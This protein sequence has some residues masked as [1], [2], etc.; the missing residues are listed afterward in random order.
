M[1]K[2][3]NSKS[4]ATI[5]TAP[6]LAAFESAEVEN[7]IRAGLPNGNKLSTDQ[8][9]AAALAARS[10]DLNPFLRE[11][12]ITDAG[13]MK[14][15]A[16]DAAWANEWMRAMG[17]REPE[18]SYVTPGQLRREDLIEWV[19]KLNRSIDDSADLATAFRA[20]CEALNY[21]P[22]T[23]V[24]VLAR[25]HRF[26]TRDA[27]VRNVQAALLLGTKE[28]VRALYGL[29]PAPDHEAWGIV[30]ASEYK[31]QKDSKGAVTKTAKDAYTEAGSKYNHL[32]R[33]KKRA[34]TACYRATVPTNAAQIARLREGQ[35]TTTVTRVD[36]P[37]AAPAAGIVVPPPM[38]RNDELPRVDIIDG[39][40]ELLAEDLED[41]E[42]SAAVTPSPAVDAIA[43][44]EDVSDDDDDD[45]TEDPVDD[46]AEPE[47]LKIPA[48]VLQSARDVATAASNFAAN[49]RTTTEKQDKLINM[50]LERLTAKSDELRH[51]L[52]KALTGQEH[53][54]DL[55]G[56][57][58]LALLN[59]WIKLTEPADGGYP[60]PCARA[61]RDVAAL[62]KAMEASR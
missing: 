14:A 21:N 59:A 22:A 60:Q 50:H 2:N 42:A 11:I 31:D 37:A 20:F 23:D 28:E 51:A 27:W 36:G 19:R 26:S 61:G 10:T 53:Y 24:A 15:A 12:H 29:A 32:E 30:R 45:E 62:K 52:L 40:A 47:P 25:M 54:A 55:P 48:D 6:S 56:S 17:E 38:P 58:R 18:F 4:L 7:A 1:A 9:R 43:E 33:A 3:D 57:M 39:Q 13:V 8:V 16:A 46:E 44:A 41:L 35:R 34:R 49:G 5:K